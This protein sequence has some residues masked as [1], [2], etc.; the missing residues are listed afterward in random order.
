MR[1]CSVHIRLR[2][3]SAK[4]ICSADPECTQ[5]SGTPKSEAHVLVDLTTKSAKKLVGEPPATVGLGLCSQLFIFVSYDSPFTASEFSA[6]KLWLPRNASE[7][8]CTVTVCG[9]YVKRVSTR[10]DCSDL[11]AGFFPFFGGAR[12][13]VATESPA[14]PSST[15]R[16]CPSCS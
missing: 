11:D 16:T 7:L 9:S 4:G 3:R 13:D 10:R 1:N 14:D 15:S 6:L 5:H 8:D 2:S 12:R